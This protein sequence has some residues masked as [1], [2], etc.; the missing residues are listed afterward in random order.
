MAKFVALLRA[1]NVGGAGKLPMADLKSMCIDAGFDCVETYISS[2]NVLFESKDRAARVQAELE[3]RLRDYAQK[4][5]RVFLRTPGQLQEIL[6]GNPF[7]KAQSNLTYVF[8]LDG[9]PAPDATTNVLHRVDEELCAGKREI[10]VH[11]PSGMGQSKLV[12]PAA[13]HATARNMNTIAKLVTM[14]S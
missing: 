6:R 13:K 5:I 1:V 12:I 7:P 4:P 2:G 9:K 3:T 10:Y 14:S 8:F 11:Y